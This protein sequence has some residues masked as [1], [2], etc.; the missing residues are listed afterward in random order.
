MCGEQKSV[1]AHK[2]HERK[3]KRTDI[4]KCR[5]EKL[6]NVLLDLVAHFEGKVVKLLL[7]PLSFTLGRD[8]EDCYVVRKKK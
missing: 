7:K 6:S 8:V 5:I 1:T 4:V 3:N 2:S